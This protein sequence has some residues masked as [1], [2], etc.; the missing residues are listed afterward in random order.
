M[1]P[2]SAKNSLRIASWNVRTLYE[3]GKCKQ[4]INEM[5]RNK[6]HIL[7]ISESHWIQFGQKRLQTGEE[8]LFS[9]KDQGPHREGVALILSKAAKKTLRGWEAHGSRIIMA[10]FS[11]TN[12][13]INMN[14]VQIYA[15][16]NDDDD[17][18]KDNFYNRLQTVIEN[19][20][21]K[22]VN[23][24]MGDANAKVGEDNTGFEDVMGKQGLGQMNENGERFANMCSFNRLVIGGTVFPHKKIHRA[25]WVSPDQRT[26]NQID[27]FCISGKFRRSL[28]DVRVLRGADIGSD[29]HLLLAVLRLRLKRF[30]KND[31]YRRQKYQVSLL[32]GG[33]N[34]KEE[35]KLSLKNKF[36][37]LEVK[38][39]NVEDHWSH[40]KETLT[41]TCKEVLGEKERKHKEWIS[42]ESLEKIA[43]R[44]TKKE[45]VNRART[46]TEKE[47]A[48]QEYTIAAKD[49]KKNIKKD[50]EK[51]LTDLAERAEKAAQSGHTRVLY[52]T[53]KLI[54]G[55]SN[56]TVA[57]V[58]DKNGKTIFDRETQNRRWVEH[59]ESLL[60][61]PPPDN[62]PDILSA[63]KDLPISCEP[64]TREETAKA[65]TQL[66]P[67][68]AAG[69]D[70]IPP[71]ALKADIETT[72]DILHELFVKIWKEEQFPKDW[73]EGHLVKLPKKGDLGNCNNYRG[74]TL[75]S[76]PGKIFNRIILNRI[77]DTVDNSLRDEQAGFRKNRSCTDQIAALRIIIEQSHEWNS[78]LIINFIDY[79][80]AF[81]SIDRTTLWKIMRHYGIP[82]KLVTLVEKMYDGTTCRVINEG[83]LTGSFQIKTGVR[84]GCLLSP[85]LFI[86]A[87]D[88]LM[89]E[90]TR[91]KRNGI[92]W[93]LWSQLDDLDFADDIALLS[94]N[95]EQMQN[96]TKLLKDASQ[97]I[98]LKI[99]PGKSK[100]LKVKTVGTDNIMVG[101]NQLEVVSEFTY[102]GSIV[103][104]KGGTGADI[105]ARIG[106]ARIAF[107]SLNK[108]WKDRN[109]SRKTKIKLFNSNVKSVLLYGSETWSLTKTLTS[110]LQVFINTCL[111]R[112]MKIRWNDKV[113]NKILWE[114]TGQRQMAEEIGRRKWRWIGHTLRKPASSTIRHALQWNPQGQR[115]RGRPQTTWR[116]QV[117]EDMKRGEFGWK[118]AARNA[119]DR[120][121]WKSV[122][123]G[124]YPDTG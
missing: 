14:I 39:R 23:I 38:S 102:L 124:L 59:F 18:E 46:R 28:E 62:P 21:T 86:L 123:C 43:V 26:E 75:L 65:A 114:R 116:R 67:N 9:G 68:K 6:L 33:L 44:R 122:V 105:K 37:A 57:T 4:A 112:I 100:I 19:L 117:E 10:S 110:K 32:Q 24:V 71:E 97:A 76:I 13:R 12:K 69:P 58:K 7:G 88:W 78:P 20:P 108:V 77:K 1:P 93:T 42:Q 30:D 113:Q 50:K 40:V 52:Q 82:Q 63:R 96:K 47:T 11:T 51:Y 92:Q 85:F 61:R 99:H 36:Q 104:D 64:P 3:A 66:H 103:D 25:T 35:F 72:T 15:P 95:H 54:S 118:E 16:T 121:R 91:G 74:I 98:G 73:K 94:H 31:G 45:A 48:H 83:Q 8:I 2:S 55:R 17:E 87:L 84:Q 80:K 49:V 79:E 120:D 107:S 81:D 22:D 53:T 34:R 70:A 111:R 60:N 27:H 56:S 89:K 101:N 109:I 115:G 29:H 5:H 119:Q 90:V 106:K 41:A